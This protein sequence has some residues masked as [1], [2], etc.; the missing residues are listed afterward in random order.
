M[1]MCCPCWNRLRGALR[2]LSPRVVGGRVGSS[3]Q[4]WAGASYMTQHRPSL[5]KGGLGWW[6]RTGKEGRERGGGIINPTW[7][8]PTA[9]PDWVWGSRAMYQKRARKSPACTMWCRSTGTHRDNP[10]FPFCWLQLPSQLLN[11]HQDLSLV[12]GIT[13]EKGF[14][15]RM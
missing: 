3:C 1:S 6:A 7:P 13:R 9:H 11:R 8:L 2:C 14:L 4:G 5:H 10:T 12:L 15:A